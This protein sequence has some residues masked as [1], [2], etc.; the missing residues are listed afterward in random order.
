MATEHRSRRA[1]AIHKGRRDAAL[2]V[3]DLRTA[4]ADRAALVALVV[5]DEP[6]VL[7]FMAT[8]L[9]RQGWSVLEATDGVA[10][11]ALAD[12]RPLDLLVTDYEM[13]SVTGV[14]LAEQLRERREDLPV[15]MVSGHLDAARK[16]RGLRGRTAF[17]RKPFAAKELVSSIGSILD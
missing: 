4:D 2:G 3:D 10:A 11:L 8:V 7:R 13:P 16:M 15:L 1:R 14:A 9:R 12:T 17:A 5:D 6:F